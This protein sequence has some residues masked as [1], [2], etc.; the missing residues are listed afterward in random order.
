[1]FDR[2]IQQQ[3]K[4]GKGVSACLLRTQYRMHPLISLWPNLMFYNGRLSDGISAVRRKP[5]R[6]FPWPEMGPLAFVPVESH[7]ETGVGLGPSKL[8]KAECEVF[9]LEKYSLLSCTI[10]MHPEGC[11]E[12]K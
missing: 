1:M 6:G 2:L 10:Q 7:E 5:P 8:N 12:K 4:H 9:Q 11:F 3:E